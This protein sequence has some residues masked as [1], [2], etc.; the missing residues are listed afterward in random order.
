MPVSICLIFNW[1]LS[2]FC[3]RHLVDLSYENAYL[4]DCRSSQKGSGCLLGHNVS[5]DFLLHPIS[6]LPPFHLSI[7][8]SLSFRSPIGHWNSV[9][10]VLLHC[11]RKVIWVL[12][13]L[14][15]LYG[16]LVYTPSKAKLDQDN[17]LDMTVY[18]II[19]QIWG[20]S[21]TPKRDFNKHIKDMGNWVT[22][23]QCSWASC[24]K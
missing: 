9:W 21:S 17:Y 19:L 18:L 6:L 8:C 11:G 22:G 20:E 2:K 7:F 5:L 24:V 10:E 14:G 4:C 16:F 1:I 3:V 23:A 12:S 15:A 13:C